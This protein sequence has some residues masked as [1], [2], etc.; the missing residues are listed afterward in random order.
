[1]NHGMLFER[2]GKE[3]HPFVHHETMQGPLEEGRENRCYHE[4]DC[5]PEEERYH[6]FMGLRILAQAIGNTGF[7]QIVG[8]PFKTD[9]VAD[10]EAHKVP[11]HLAG[12][13]GQDFVLII[14]HDAEH[15]AGQNRLDRPFQFN[16]LFTTHILHC[17]DFPALGAP[18]TAYGF[19]AWDLA[20]NRSARKRG[21]YGPLAQA[22][23]ALLLRAP[24]LFL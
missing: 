3:T 13:M 4:T 2:V 12:D 9:T 14:Q 18:K 23:I 20:G 21:L 6:G 1:M 24:E 10:G 5:R 19:S 7:G 22:I 8:G 11:P 17:M 16:G 15:G